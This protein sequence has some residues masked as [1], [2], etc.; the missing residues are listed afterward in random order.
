[1]TSPASRSDRTA[2]VEQGHT[3]A[4]WDQKAQA[5]SQLLDMQGV[6][7]I[8]YVNRDG[9]TRQTATLQAHLE[10]VGRRHSNLRT[11]NARI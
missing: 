6:M 10:S 1:M 7:R 5:S 4:M 2:E 11:D 8:R 3:T 9:L